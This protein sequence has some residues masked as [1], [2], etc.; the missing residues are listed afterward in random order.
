MNSLLE[1]LVA[2]SRI[3]AMDTL[4]KEQVDISQITE[5]VVHEAEK[6][7]QDKHIALTARIQEGIEKKVHKNSLNIIIK[8]ILENAYK[9]TPDG[10]AIEIALDAKKL[11]ISDTGKGIAEK[12]LERIRERF[13]QADR[14]K[15]DTKSFGL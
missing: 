15:T 8:N 7:H 5:T 2:I 10:G 14:S 13:R 9:F 12:D 4:S 1:T 3:E 11:I 6:I